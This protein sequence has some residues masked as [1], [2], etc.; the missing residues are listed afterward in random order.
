ML[1]NHDGR[2]SYLDLLSTFFTL[3]AVN[4]RCA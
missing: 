4:G 1:Q 2:N 3:A